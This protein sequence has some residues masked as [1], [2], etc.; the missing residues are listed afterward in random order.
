M[1]CGEGGRKKTKN[2]AVREEGSVGGSIKECQRRRRS[3]ASSLRRRMANKKGALFVLALFL[4]I[5]RAPLDALKF[6]VPKEGHR[7]AAAA[8]SRGMSRELPRVSA[9]F[10]LTGCSPLSYDTS[11]MV[12]Y[13]EREA[14]EEGYPVLEVDGWVVRAFDFKELEYEISIVGQQ[15][16]QHT[17]VVRLLEVRSEVDAQM[18]FV[19]QMSYVA[20]LGCPLT[21]GHSDTQTIAVV[22]AGFSPIDPSTCGK[23]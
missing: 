12:Y 17:A 7:Y 23:P 22:H 6:I 3:A 5:H 15:V 11:E 4:V 13:F 2:V 19:L 14:H 20:T 9:I 8:S 10:T 16:G 18:C 21:D 1:A